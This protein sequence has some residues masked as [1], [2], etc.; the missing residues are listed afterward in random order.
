MPGSQ[1]APGAVRAPAVART[2]VLPSATRTA[3]APGL[4]SIFAA[5]WLAYAIPIDASPPPSRTAARHGD[6]HLQHCRSQPAFASLEK[7]PE[8]RAIRL[9][10]GAHPD[11]RAEIFRSLSREAQ[12]R[13][14]DQLNEDAKTSLSRILKYP[15]DQAGSIM[16]TEFVSV[17]ASWMVKQ[18]IDHIRSP[19][20]QTEQIYAVYQVDPQSQRLLQA[21]SLRELLIA[22]PECPSEN[23]LNGRNLL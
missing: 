23:M 19:C 1:T 15:A 12:G 16:T 20:A 4:T 22:N 7:L 9:L 3:S 13:L 17:P 21:V 5:Q 6:A 14:F 18:V 2:S 8:E 11:R 10:G